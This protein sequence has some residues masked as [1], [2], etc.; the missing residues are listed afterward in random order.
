MSEKMVDFTV[1]PVVQPPVE[2]AVEQTVEL[3]GRGQRLLAVLIDGVILLIITLPIMMITGALV[4]LRGGQPLSFGQEAFYFVL[5]WGIFVA[6]HGRLLSKNGQTIGKKLMGVR[7]ISYSDQQ[8][9]PL[10]RLFGLRYLPMGLVAQIPVIGGL[11][12]LLDCLFIFGS[13]KRCIHDL[14][15]GTAVVKA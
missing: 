5:G 14:I 13:E 15:A 12:G 1:E 7:I 9:L 2:L 8:I 3:A 10:G 6:V 4:Q 11:I